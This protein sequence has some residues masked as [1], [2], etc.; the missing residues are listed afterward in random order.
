MMHPRLFAYSSSS[1]TSARPI[2]S[3][4]EPARLACPSVLSTSTCRKSSSSWHPPV[5]PFDWASLTICRTPSPSASN[6]HPPSRTH[7]H[8]RTCPPPN[9][10]R[11]YRRVGLNFPGPIPLPCE[12]ALLCLAFALPAGQPLLPAA[13]GVYFLLAH[14]TFYFCCL[15]GLSLLPPAGSHPK[16]HSRSAPALALALALAAAKRLRRRSLVLAG[17]LAGAGPWSAGSRGGWSD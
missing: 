1:A 3:R 13:A 15:L 4:R 10:R 5:R 16:L 12:A 8:T 2:S 9:R 6:P 17:Q 14:S 11:W 7:T